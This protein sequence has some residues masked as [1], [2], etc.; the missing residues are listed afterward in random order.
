MNVLIVVLLVLGF[1]CFAAATG[2]M[3]ARFN[4]VAAGLACWILT[5]MIPALVA[6]G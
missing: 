4:L 6:L 5:E 3:P 2:G 1:I